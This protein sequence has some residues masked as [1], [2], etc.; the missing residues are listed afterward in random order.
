MLRKSRSE[1]SGVNLEVN[2]RIL[3]S[4]TELMK[5]IQIL[6]QR[7]KDLQREIVAE[8]MVRQRGCSCDYVMGSALWIV[9]I[10]TV[11]VFVG[12]GQC[13]SQK[14]STRS[15]AAGQKGSS[16]LPSKLASEPLCLC[17]YHCVCVCVCVCWCG[18]MRTHANVINFRSLSSSIFV[19]F[20]FAC[21]FLNALW[22]HAFAWMN[23]L[24]I[25]TCDY[26]STSHGSE[27]YRLMLVLTENFLLEVHFHDVLAFLSVAN[28]PTKLCLERGSLSS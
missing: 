13:W 2:E 4:C 11:C 17:E 8:G 23:I 15:T 26:R 5:A 19:P 16:L 25:N 3:D 12:R 14:S 9:I 20:Q 1:Q 18:Y 6:M 22:K 10:C 27:T 21:L 28:R 24:E 7:S